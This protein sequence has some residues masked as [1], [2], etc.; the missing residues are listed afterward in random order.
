MKVIVVGE[1]PFISEVGQLCLAAG[2]ETHL[3]LAE[4]VQSA[5]ENG[6]LLQQLGDTDVAIE[7]YHESLEGKRHLLQ[8][9]SHTLNIRALLL[10]SALNSS[11]TQSASWLSIPQRVVGFAVLPPLAATGMVELARALQTEDA[12]LAEAQAFWQQMGWETAVVVD[13]PGLVRARTVCCLINEAASAV[14]EGVATAADID[15]AMRLGANYPRGPLAWADYLGLDAV[16]GVMQALFQEWGEDRYR[17]SPLLR[18]LVMAGRL[19]EKSGMGFYAH[20]AEP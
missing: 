16:L 5:Q 3:Y 14:F 20:K 2:H 13:G 7:L 17:P 9:L 11:A 19:G 18:R 15:Q 4:D 8:A 6:R 12:A 10:T 1:I